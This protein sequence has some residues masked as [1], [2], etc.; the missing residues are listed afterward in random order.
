MNM[1]PTFIT[2]LPGVQTCGEHLEPADGDFITLEWYG[3]ERG[4]IVVL[5]CTAWEIS[6]SKPRMAYLLI[7]LQN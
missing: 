4:A 7:N 6:V 1:L 3:E 2:S 5:F